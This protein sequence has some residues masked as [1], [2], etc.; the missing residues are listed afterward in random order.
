MKNYR[1]K[2]VELEIDPC[3]ITIQNTLGK[4]GFGVVKKGLWR[5]TGI[6]MK[7]IPT[8][9]N[10]HEFEVELDILSRLH[11]PNICQLLGASTY[12]NPYMIV[13]EYMSNGSL[14]QHINKLSYNRKVDV[15]KD[16]SKGIAYL[17]HRKPNSIIHRDLKPSNILLTVSF[18][19]KI[20]D[21][22]ISC[23]QTGENEVY[24]MTGETGTYRYMA[25][26]VF[27]H[28]N[29]GCKVD[30]WSFGMILYHLFVEPPFNEMNSKILFECIRK[31]E[32]PI[33][34]ECLKNDLKIL[35]KKCIAIDCNQRWNSMYIVQYC[36]SELFYTKRNRF[37]CFL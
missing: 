22:G 7:I 36:N 16:I 9:D 11:H 8:I 12:E 27:K 35:L 10:F 21:F 25:P 31:N 6:A 29:Y 18:K 5:G 37:S 30:V 17:H 19:A 24:Q 34:W 28:E 20:A 15:I 33:K 32:I 3:E 1:M 23:L 2:F 13:M 4:G 26:E 14:D